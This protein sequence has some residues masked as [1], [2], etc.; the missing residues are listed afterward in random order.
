MRRNTATTIAAI[1]FTG[2]LLIMG[3]VREAGA[4]FQWAGCLKPSSFYA[5]YF[6]Y[7]GVGEQL[8]I[9]GFKYLQA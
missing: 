8:D 5:Y 2:K 3:T 1:N 4:R 9:F 7:G 6:V